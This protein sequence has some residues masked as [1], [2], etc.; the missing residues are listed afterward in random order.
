M[1]PR[2]EWVKAQGSEDFRDWDF[3]PGNSYSSTDQ[4]GLPFYIWREARDNRS[5]KSRPRYCCA[6][7]GSYPYPDLEPWTLYFTFFN[8][9]LN[10]RSTGAGKVFGIVAALVVLAVFIITW[11]GDRPRGPYA[12]GSPIGL[13]I[14]AAF[15]YSMFL[16][17]VVSGIW[18]AVVNVYRWNNGR[19][20][21]EGQLQHVPLAHLQ[22]FQVISA[23]DAG[24]ATGQQ[25]AN[26]HGLAAIFAD[27]SQI[28]LRGSPLD[29]ESIAD[30]HSVMTK[31]FIT[32]QAELEATW[33]ERAKRNAAEKALA[34]NEPGQPGSDAGTTVAGSLKSGVPDKL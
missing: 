27:G 11:L 15:L 13:V 5:G 19:F 2:D 26:L 6:T 28:I 20:K 16:A 22:G 12:V 23:G 24:A 29:Y 30:Q 7:I 18:Y 32:G 33:A 9:S 17:P 4:L 8:P 3:E 31:L 1:L 21:D 34:G 14:I 25:A 10:V